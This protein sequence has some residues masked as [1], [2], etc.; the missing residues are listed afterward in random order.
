MNYIKIFG[1]DEVSVKK[2]VS[3]TNIINEIYSTFMTER[4]L[5]TIMSDVIRT[6]E[7]VVNGYSHIIE[8][9]EKTNNY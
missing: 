2:L 5:S 7:G 1:E 9:I 4:G 8:K 6:V 3:E